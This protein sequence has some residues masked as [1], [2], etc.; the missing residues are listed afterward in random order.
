MSTSLGAAYE[1]SHMGTEAN[2][3]MEYSSC[4][5]N[6]FVINPNGLNYIEYRL[7]TPQSNYPNRSQ[8]ASNL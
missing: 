1:L 4:P 5:S 3:L 8:K 7:F 6:Y 2:H